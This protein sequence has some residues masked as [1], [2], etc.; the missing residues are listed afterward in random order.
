MTDLP[1][2]LDYG[3]VLN[4]APRLRVDEGVV[5]GI[6]GGAEG[7]VSIAW[8]EDSGTLEAAVE[9]DLTRMLSEPAMVLVDYQPTTVGGVDA[10]RTFVL[11]A[12]E[13]A[14]AREQWRL[15]AAGRR[16]TVSAVTALAD[17]PLWGPRLAEVA[18]TFPR[19]VIAFDPETGELVGSASAVQALLDGDERVENR[20]FA[21]ALDAARAPAFRVWTEGFDPAATV[22]GDKSLCV[23]V[24]E[25]PEGERAL[26]PTTTARLP[27][28][29]VAWLGLSPRPT[30][31]HPAIRLSPGQMAV[32]I[33][34]GQAH[35]H[36]L[37]PRWR[38]SCKSGSTPVSG[39]GRPGSPAVGGGATSRCWRAS[40]GSGASG[41]SRENS[42]SWRPH[43]RPQSSAS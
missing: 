10:I 25:R 33:G 40:A 22:L 14:S 41:R 17:Q 29:L 1:F 34:R 32:V 18:T 6:A 38:M 3:D 43:R 12:G 31:E 11:D 16:W 24:T 8:L 4:P 42:S 19:D 39:T 30:P 9:E 36:D 28:A 37:P 5:F 2:T 20:A 26:L 21:A 35:G 7:L 27:V 23:L 15:M 13:L